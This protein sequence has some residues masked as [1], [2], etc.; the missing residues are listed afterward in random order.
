M[1]ENITL[2]ETDKD[3]PKHVRNGFMRYGD[4]QPLTQGGEAVLRTCVDENLG[5]T[6]VMKTLQPQYQ[7]LETYQKRFLREARVTAQIPHPATIPVYELSRDADGNA[8][9]TMKRLRGRDLS[10]ILDKIAESDADTI[11]NFPRE[12]IIR[13]LLQCAECLAFAHAQGVVHR[14]M[15]PANIMIGDYNEVTVLDWGLAKVSSFDDTYN[16]AAARTLR[17]GQQ[18][19]PGRLTGPGDVQGTPFYMSPE[20]AVETGDVDERSDIYNMGIILFEVLTNESYMSGKSFK[21][22]KR[23]LL[24][25]PTREPMRVTPKKPISREFNA[26]S[27]KALQK[28]AADRYQTMHAFVDDLRGAHTGTGVSVYHEPRL[29]RMMRP[30]SRIALAVATFIWMLSGAAALTLVQWLLGVFA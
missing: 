10:D 1:P 6:V 30:G 5:R 25:D 9:F 21:E 15:K 27:V 19:I 20:Q 29:V 11:R 28:N 8:Y 7:N 2:S 17:S 18:N 12:R 26:V 14:D 23:K 3:L 16:A 24:E 22:I 4:F 13:A